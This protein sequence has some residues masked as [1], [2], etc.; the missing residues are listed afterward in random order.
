MGTCA[1]GGR[2]HECDKII[3][4]GNFLRNNRISIARLSFSMEYWSGGRRHAN[5]LAQEGYLGAFGALLRGRHWTSPSTSPEVP[6]KTPSER[7][8]CREGE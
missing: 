4:A 6:K 2:A 5:F 7:L 8:E 3:F 1:R